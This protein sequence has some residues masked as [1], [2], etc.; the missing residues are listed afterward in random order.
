MDCAEG[1][2]DTLEAEVRPQLAASYRCRSQKPLPGLKD[3]VADP[4]K[5]DSLG[6]S[7][8]AARITPTHA[9]IGDCADW[10]DGGHFFGASIRTLLQPSV[11]SVTHVIC[12]DIK[13]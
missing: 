7:Y 9:E 3:S 6:G 2:A 12:R 10:A 11:V 8:E 13:C 1:G 4:V 5:S